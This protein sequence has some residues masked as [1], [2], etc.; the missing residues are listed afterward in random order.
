[1]APQGDLNPLAEVLRKGGQQLDRL[2]ARWALVGGL[3]VAVRAEPRLT[4]DVDLAVAVADDSQAEALVFQLQD[5]GYRV[6]ASVEQKST[7]RLA[8]IR[9]LPPHQPDPAVVLDLLF[10]SSGIEE[11]IVASANT[12]EVF[13]GISLPVATIGHLIA[14]KVLARDDRNRPQDHDDLMALLDNASPDDVQQSRDA[15]RQVEGLGFQR[16]RNLERDLEE[17]L[18]ERS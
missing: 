10:A 12:L 4:R 7:G 1:M 17:L 6:L 18:A 2:G 14:L 13:P 5:R 9:L 16:G 11:G 3:A 15:L 8:T